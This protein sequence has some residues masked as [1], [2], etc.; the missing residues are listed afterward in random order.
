MLYDITCMWNVKKK[1]S[2]YNN[3]E[4]DSQIQRKNL[5]LQNEKGKRDKLGV[6]D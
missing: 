1:T 2:E 6:W 5:C 4:R 3:T